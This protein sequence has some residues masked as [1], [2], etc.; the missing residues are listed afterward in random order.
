[1]DIDER[2]TTTKTVIET[3]QNLLRLKQD[4]QNCLSNFSSSNI[5]KVTDLASSTV[6]DSQKRRN[7]EGNK[8]RSDTFEA[9]FQKL[10]LEFS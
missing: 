9:K 7:C 6:C 2:P 4:Y 1:M 5:K 3:R 10:F 8:A